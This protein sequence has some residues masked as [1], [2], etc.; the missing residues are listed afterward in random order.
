MMALSSSESTHRLDAPQK[1]REG[2]GWCCDVESSATA[3]TDYSFSSSSSPRKK[4]TSSHNRKEALTSSQSPTSSSTATGLSSSFSSSSSSLQQTDKFSVFNVDEL[5]RA[6]EGKALHAQKIWRYI[7]QKNVTNFR[8]IPDLP[9]RVYHRL[10]NSFSLHCCLVENLKTSS[11]GSTTKLLLKMQ[12][13]SKIEIC[14]MRYG[15]VH[16]D[17]FPDE[18]RLRMKREKKEQMRKA[19]GGGGGGEEEEGKTER[20]KV[21]EKEEKEKEV[22]KDDMYQRDEREE[23]K[24]RAVHERKT[25]EEEGSER[26]EEE[27]E[28]EGRASR[29]RKERKLFKSNRRATVCLS[30][31][32]RKTKEKRRR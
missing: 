19:R 24:E 14:I 32:V 13:G 21:G 6:V 22:E 11:D 3:C 15:A 10:E 2:I 20:K 27:E 7:I 4:S 16:Y 28:K 31:Q 26:E 25:E 8:E 29:K 5:L 30:A 12:D 17:V 23:E 18:E 9:K 1:G